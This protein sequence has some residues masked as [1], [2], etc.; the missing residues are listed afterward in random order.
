VITKSPSR[1][2]SPMYL[3][4]LGVLAAMLV[5]APKATPTRTPLLSLGPITI[6]NGTATVAGTLGP[7]VSSAVFVVNGQQLGVDATG[8]FAGVIDLNG[9]TALQLVISRPAGLMLQ[10]RIPLLGLGVIP[11]SILDSLLNA[12]LRVLPPAGGGGLPVTISGSVLDRT[13]L[14]GLTVNGIPTLGLLDSNGSFNVQLPGTTKIVTVTATSHNGTSQTISQQVST[15]SQTVS[16]RDAVGLRI[17]QIRYIRKG[18]LR[19][20]RVRMIVT[21]KDARGLLVRGATIR[22]QARGHRLAKRPILKQS[23]PRGRATIVL[24]LRKSSFGKRLF[25]TTVAK[26]PTAKARRTTSAPMPRR[27]H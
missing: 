25:T 19:T 2:L 23:G 6:A 5:L 24:K 15:T 1:L 17:A 13:Q 4:A 11:G 20:R 7:D 26:T 21:L 8:H 9:A 18:V 16:A 10:F 14:I 3:C 22:V 27:R 12:G